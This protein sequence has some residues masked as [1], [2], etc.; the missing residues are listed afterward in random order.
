LDKTRTAVVKNTTERIVAEAM[1]NTKGEQGGKKRGGG[2]RGRRRRGSKKNRKRPQPAATQ[3]QEV[4]IDLVYSIRRRDKPVRMVFRRTSVADVRSV[5]PEWPS[6]S[7]GR[8]ALDRY[9]QR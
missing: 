8:R 7:T 3:A 6:R 4:E 2:N 9:V 5:K 1:A